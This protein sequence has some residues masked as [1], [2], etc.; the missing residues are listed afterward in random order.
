MC[1]ESGRSD[2]G[3]LVAD[4]LKSFVGK[5]RTVGAELRPESRM[6]CPVGDFLR[7]RD[8]I[9]PLRIID[10]E[11]PII[12]RVRMTKSPSEIDRVRTIC[13]IASQAFEELPYKLRIA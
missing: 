11:L 6:G 1:Q 2:G 9:A 13:Q 3:S 5:E 8:M 12:R 10:C 4:A 7:M